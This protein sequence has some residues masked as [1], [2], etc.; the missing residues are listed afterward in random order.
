MKVCAITVIADHED[1]LP[2]IADQ[3]ANAINIIQY[4]TGCQLAQTQINIQIA[5]ILPEPKDEGDGQTCD[6]IGFRIGR[7]GC[8]C[9]DDYE[10]ELRNPKRKGL[11]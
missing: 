1:R 5:P 11:K 6:A 4:R 10:E 8:D 9:E 7:N 2:A 3:I